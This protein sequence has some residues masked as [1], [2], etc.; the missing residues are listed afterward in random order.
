MASVIEAQRRKII[1]LTE[2]TILL[3]ALLDERDKQIVQ[4]QQKE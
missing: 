4:L 3:S 1:S 2:E